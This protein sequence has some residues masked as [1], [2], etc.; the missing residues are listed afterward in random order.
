MREIRHSPKRRA[1]LLATVL[2]LGLAVPA[3]AE[4]SCSELFAIARL[5]GSGSGTAQGTAIAFV[6]GTPQFVSFTSV[7]TG[8]TVAQ[9]WSFSQGSV[10]VV[11][12]PMPVLLSGPFQL[13]DS[14]VV[15]QAPN[16]G[17]WEY[18][19]TF[20]EN[21]NLASFVVT[22]DLCFGT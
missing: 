12:S 22:G 3:A 17:E 11:E 19:G 5:Q 2:V 15:V 21:T 7:I 13:I 6:D 18:Q 20:N 10:D 4:P 1:L 9:T 14:D 16:S 8:S